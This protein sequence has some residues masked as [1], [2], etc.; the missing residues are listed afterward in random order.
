M[1]ICVCAY[2]RICVCAYVRMCVCA[3]VPLCVC[4]YMLNTQARHIHSN[5]HYKHKH[6]RTYAGS[7]HPQM[8]AYASSIALYPC[9]QVSDPDNIVVLHLLRDIMLDPLF[10][11]QVQHIHIRYTHHVCTHTCAAFIALLCILPYNEIKLLE[12]YSN[13]GGL[14]GDFALTAS[15]Q[16][17]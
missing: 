5:A 8:L 10:P 12:V 15:V 3:Y 4:A 17:P 2:V 9:V 11:L 6:V 13:A 1:R 14:C 16:A 7:Q